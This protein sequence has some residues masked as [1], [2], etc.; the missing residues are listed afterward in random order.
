MHEHGTEKKP[1]SLKFAEAF[2]AAKVQSAAPYH[3]DC[4]TLKT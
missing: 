4:I 2:F 3:R 1:T